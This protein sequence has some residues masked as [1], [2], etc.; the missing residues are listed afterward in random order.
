MA[1]AN[2][3]QRDLRDWL[4]D[5]PRGVPAS[6][7]PDAE[8]T[9][10]PSTGTPSHASNGPDADPIPDPEAPVLSSGDVPINDDWALSPSSWNRWLA[11]PRRFWLSRQRLPSR[12]SMA[13]SIGTAVHAATEA[14]LELEPPDDAEEG[15]LIPLA[16]EALI[17]A[18]SEARAEFLAS[19][20]HPAWKESRLDDAR[21][22]LEG[23]LHLL[24][25]RCIGHAGRLQRVSPEHWV[26]V[27]A[28]TLAV[29]VGL[30]SE[31]GR[32]G[33][34]VDQVVRLEPSSGPS[35]VV[36]VD[37]K[38]GRVP[39][40]ELSDDVQRQLL[41][42]RDLLIEGGEHR[43]HPVSTEAWYAA[44]PRIIPMDGPAVADR[45]RADR[46]KM[47]LGPDPMEATP[48][49]AACRW[50][51]WKAW[52]PSWMDPRAQ[53]QRRRGTFVDLVAEVVAFDEE[54]GVARLAPQ[55]LASEAG[56]VTGTGEEV[57]AVVDGLALERLGRIASVG[58]RPLVFVS[59]VRREAEHLRA[60]DW[61][62]VLPYAPL[63]RG[64]RAA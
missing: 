48:S 23:L 15:W 3:P 20:R 59:G 29:E 18:W 44:G 54:A 62:D 60:G 45:A 31:D 50:C 16:R 14:L 12:P 5:D 17:T 7:Q 47:V 10:G 19:P 55:V 30:E 11:C 22:L 1:D 41:F 28:A 57:G 25:H 4:T 27:Q 46:A 61:C 26:D 58:E 38:T 43:S 36:V 33:G 32:L 35:E 34:R 42:Y 13:A 8:P 21:G 52:C 56:D 63:H 51:E 2:R 37:W 9:A 49:E 40:G 24:L 53:A 39:G 6:L 64:R